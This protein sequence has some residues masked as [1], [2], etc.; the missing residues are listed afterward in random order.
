MH[1]IRDRAEEKTQSSNCRQSCLARKRRLRTERGA[2]KNAEIFRSNARY[3]HA[4]WGELPKTTMSSL[5]EVAHS[6]TVDIV[7]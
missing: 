4:I 1:R 3:A 2:L 6:R 5:R 7:G